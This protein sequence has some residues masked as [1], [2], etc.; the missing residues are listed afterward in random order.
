MCLYDE[1][2]YVVPLLNQVFISAF[3]FCWPDFATLLSICELSFG[4]IVKCVS[5]REVLLYLT[6]RT[7]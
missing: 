3:K 1:N 7:Q 5:P 4:G 6:L 2:T